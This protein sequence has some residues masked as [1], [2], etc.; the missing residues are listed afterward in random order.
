MGVI[1]GRVQLLTELLAPLQEKADGMRQKLD[2][3]TASLSQVQ[4]ASDY[5]LQAIAEVKQLVS[6]LAAGDPSQA[7]SA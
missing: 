6:T 2:D 5:Q 4:E 3:M 1:D 7:V